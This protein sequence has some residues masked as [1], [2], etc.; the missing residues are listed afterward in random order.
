MKVFITACIGKERERE[1]RDDLCN[2]EREGRIGVRGEG[3][4]R[5]EREPI[6]GEEKGEGKGESNKPSGKNKGE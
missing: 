3:G 4:G 2:R 6:G 1:R 5:D